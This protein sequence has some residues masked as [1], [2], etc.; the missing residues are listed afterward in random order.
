MS[1]LLMDLSVDGR[2][3]QSR[4]GWSPDAEQSEERAMLQPAGSASSEPTVHTE[5]LSLTFSD[6][7]APNRFAVLRLQQQREAPVWILDK[8]FIEVWVLAVIPES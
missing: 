2:L 4:T 8:H 7:A 6:L 3:K 1:Y 5:A